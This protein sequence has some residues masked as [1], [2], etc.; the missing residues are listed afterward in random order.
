[1]A[2]HTHDYDLVS[3]DGEVP[4][5][6]LLRETEPSLVWFE[7]NAGAGARAY[8][9]RVFAVQVGERGETVPGVE[10]YF[11]E[12]DGPSAS[13]DSAR[14]AYAAWSGPRR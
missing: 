6:I 5:E 7:M 12:I 4:R 13:I 1:V 11:V 8:G 14:R 3:V 2:Y 10:R 9:G